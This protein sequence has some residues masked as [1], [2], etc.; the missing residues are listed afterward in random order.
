MKIDITQ[1]IKG[2]DG[3]KALPN[4]ETMKDLT[5]KDVSI[6]AILAPEEKQKDGKGKYTDYEIF[7][8][9]RDAKKEIE[10]SSEE[11]SRIKEKGALVLGVLVYGQI[12]DMLEK[13]DK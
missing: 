12:V 11:I 10:L 7:V 3:I 4:S 1:K 2:L 8:K 5:L 6:N 13:K 9:L